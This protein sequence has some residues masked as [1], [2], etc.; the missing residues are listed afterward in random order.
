[1]FGWS[2]RAAAFASCSK[3]AEAVGVGRELRVDHLQGDLPVQP[4]VPCPPDLAHPA[5]PEGGEDFV[6]AELR[7][8]GENHADACYP[9]P[10]MQMKAELPSS[11]ILGHEV[12]SLLAA[13]GGRA[14]VEELRAET[15]RAFGPDALFGNCHGDSFGF[16]G[17]LDFFESAGKLAR[18]GDVVSLGRV[19][20]CSGH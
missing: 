14:T 19:P 5:R 17:L 4:R 10:L 7:A 20:S 9:P 11:V 18:E 12:L 6:W 8:G 15:A 2:S 1:M 13:R 3:R 16:D